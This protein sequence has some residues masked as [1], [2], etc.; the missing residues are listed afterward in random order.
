ME[1][2]NKRKSDTKDEN[3]CEKCENKLFASLLMDPDGQLIGGNLPSDIETPERRRYVAWGSREERWPGV[4]VSF[5]V[6][7]WIPQDATPP[8]SAGVVG[9][10]RSF[11][12]VAGDPHICAKNPWSSNGLVV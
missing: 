9:A 6:Y 3:K 11:H 1:V 2:K 10:S 12:T 4:L 7:A 5:K 8:N